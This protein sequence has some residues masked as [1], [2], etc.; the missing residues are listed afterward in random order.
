MSSAGEKSV[1]THTVGSHTDASAAILTQSTHTGL[2]SPVQRLHQPLTQSPTHTGPKSRVRSLPEGVATEEE[3]LDEEDALPR[4]QKSG[5][6]CFKRRLKTGLCNLLRRSSFLG[7][8]I[9]VAP[10]SHPI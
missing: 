4:F 7:I 9:G 6:T 1:S 3:I 10:V 8:R 2:G 5:V